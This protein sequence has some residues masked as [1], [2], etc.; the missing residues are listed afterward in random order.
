MGIIWSL[1]MLNTFNQIALSI[2]NLNLFKLPKI[3]K[4]PTYRSQVSTQ[5]S[6][7]ELYNISR[8]IHEKIKD[9]KQNHQEFN[10]VLFSFHSQP[11]YVHILPPDSWYPPKPLVYSIVKVASGKNLMVQKYEEEAR[12]VL[13]ED[14]FPFN[15]VK[16]L[17]FAGWS[18]M[19]VRTASSC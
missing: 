2:S 15:C 7:D 14:Y 12:R 19:A 18:P 9:W 5:V 16:V 4:L 10:S 3:H 17:T 13:G 1:M 6:L 11:P 8:F